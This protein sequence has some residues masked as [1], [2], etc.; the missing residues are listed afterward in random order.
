[1]ILLDTNAF[2]WLAVGETRLGPK[3]RVVIEKARDTGGIG[4]CA[5]T[6]WEISMLAERK[7]ISLN[8]DTLSWIEAALA[9]PGISLL[10][11]EPAIAVDAGRLPGNI[12]GDPADR[13]IV[14]TARHHD[15]P[16]LTGDQRIL[17]YGAAGHV[18]VID[19]RR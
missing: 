10:P 1:M 11:L 19:A 7:R 13:T 6:P 9:E 15:M 17:D 12:H 18:R 4:I 14:A 2:L 8:L 16:L 5:I 3:S